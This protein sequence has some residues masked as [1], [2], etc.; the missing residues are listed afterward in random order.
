MTRFNADIVIALL[1]IAGSTIFLVA[2][3]DIDRDSL[4]MVSAGLWPRVAI[5]LLGVLSFIY[6]GQS[7]RAGWTRP[8]RISLK[9]WLSDNRNVLAC[10][11]LYALFLLG[12]PFL[13]LLL[14][15]VLFVFLSL[16]VLGHR[17]LRAHALHLAIAVV[18]IGA[19][20]AIFTFG[21]GVILPQGEV[22]PRW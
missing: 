18:S 15:G 5:V 22:L 14:S 13:G 12:L 8:G 17:S 1:L 6:L 7:V 11:A 16:T 20:W 19:M 9:A 21:L 3:F 2:S 10:F 4:G